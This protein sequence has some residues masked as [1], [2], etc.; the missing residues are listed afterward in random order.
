LKLQPQSTLGGT[1][2]AASFVSGFRSD[3]ALLRER[4]DIGCLLLTAAVDTSAIFVAAGAVAGVDLPSEAGAIKHCEDRKALWLSPRSWLLLCAIQD[5]IGLAALINRTFPE[6]QLHAALFT[7]YLCWLELAGPQ[8]Y[9][10]LTDSA[11]ISLERHGL[12]VGH[13]K[14]TLIA[15][16]TAIVV[17]EREDVW[18]LGVE[19][20]RAR[21]FTHR[22]LSSAQTSPSGNPP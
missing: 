19:R 17:R 12:P 20:S 22:L 15:G 7:D 2:G 11:F 21:Y 10:L 5:E 8:S 3:S 16:I 18:L 13:A 9:D 1:F 6:K 14:R 4:S